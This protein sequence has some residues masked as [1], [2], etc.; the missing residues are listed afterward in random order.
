MHTLEML[1]LQGKKHFSSNVGAVL[2]QV[3]TGGGGSHLE[4]QL[5]SMNIQWL[6]QPEVMG[7]I[8]KLT[9]FV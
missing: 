3:A 4:E 2:G 9:S 6:S 1:S 7:G 5:M 8:N